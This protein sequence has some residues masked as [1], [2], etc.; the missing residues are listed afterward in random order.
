MQA[1]AGVHYNVSFSDAMMAAIAAS[2]NEPV[3]QDWQSAQ[4]FHV[5]RNFRRHQYLL[6]HL[7]GAS[8]AFDSSFGLGGHQ[9]PMHDATTRMLRGAT[10]LRMSDIGY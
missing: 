6:A 2:E 10:S 4:Y 7:F 1:I 8:P 5:I 3:T 9:I